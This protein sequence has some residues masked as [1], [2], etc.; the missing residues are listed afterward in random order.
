MKK[1]RL[2]TKNRKRDYDQLADDAT[3]PKKA[4]NLLNQEPDIEVPGDAQ[5]YCI[6][7]ARYFVDNNSLTS[8]QKSKVHKKQVAKIVENN[9]F[10]HRE[11]LA[12]AG[13]CYLTDRLLV[14]LSLF[15]FRM[16]HN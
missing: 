9:A 5:F 12:A 11:S 7:C 3:D 14:D 6:P 15:V 10:D 1:S 4:E 2:K 16:L 13:L 8:H